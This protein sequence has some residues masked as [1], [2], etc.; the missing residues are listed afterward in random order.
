MLDE[1]DG[2]KNSN[3]LEC[4]NFWKTHT[5]LLLFI[6]LGKIYHYPIVCLF[7]KKME[8]FPFERLRV[9][10]GDSFDKHITKE[11]FPFHD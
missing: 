11:R 1:C 6:Y 3:V 5:P 10:Q 8:N 7:V 4:K 9:R 2:T